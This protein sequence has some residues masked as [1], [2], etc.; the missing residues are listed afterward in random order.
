[1]EDIARRRALQ[2][3]SNLALAAGTSSVASGCCLFVRKPAPVC[4]NSPAVSYPAGP[5]TID[6]HCHVFNGT[7]LQ[8]EKFLSMVAVNQDGAL[9]AGAKF[10]GAILQRMAWKNAPSGD[11]EL[12]ELGRIASELSSCSTGQLQKAIQ[13][14]HDKGYEKAVAELKRAA[15]EVKALSRT[16]RFAGEWHKLHQLTLTE[17]AKQDEAIAYIEGLPDSRKDYPAHQVNKSM[18][19]KSDGRSFAGMVDFVIQGFQYRYVNVHDYLNTYNRPGERVIDLML[20][21]MVDYD[22]WL[23]KGERTKTTLQTQVEVMRSMSIVT[24]GRVHAF[25]PFDPLRQVAFKDRHES[26]DSLAFVQ[27]AVRKHGCV[28]VKMYPPMGFAA[29]GNETVNKDFPQFWDRPWL[30]DWTAKPGLGKRLDDELRLLYDWCQSEDVPLMAHT[31]S[32]NGV[33]EDFEGLTAATYW[34]QALSEFPRLRINF[35]HFGGS[36]PV[37]AGPTRTKE[38][39]AL[40]G[41][42]A[43]SPGSNAFADAG[44]FV[45]V[46]NSEPKLR[47]VVQQLYQDIIAGRAPLSTRFMY[48][49]DWEMTLTE[50]GVN[51]YLR[52]FVKLFNELEALPGV[53]AQGVTGLASRFF[54]RNAV[55]WIGLRSGGAARTRLDEFYNLNNVPTP[56]WAGKVDSIP[57]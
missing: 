52:D 20:P 55:D 18:S 38:F 56:D 45:E 46:L 15:R 44:Y 32:S 28:G 1:M 27:D 42:A 43:G 35:G 54:G 17:V 10:L 26:F 9:G 14:R 50:G 5:L 51:P 47:A 21:S 25:A 29:L 41:Q 53:Q 31:G 37:Q 16:E 8:I 22:Y 13:E 2:V 6:A 7:D 40:M 12:A 48:G 23:A 49:T 57:V 34:R 11:D 39:M 3:L 19:M 30:P 33:I 36:S 24:G 4:P